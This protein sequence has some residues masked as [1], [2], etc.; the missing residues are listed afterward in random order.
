MPG[1]FH[2][3]NVFCASSKFCREVKAAYLPTHPFSLEWGGGC[4][5][6]LITHRSVPPIWVYWGRRWKKTTRC[7]SKEKV[8]WNCW[9]RSVVGKVPKSR[10]YFSSQLTGILQNSS[11]NKLFSGMALAMRIYIYGTHCV[12]PDICKRGIKSRAA[13]CQS[14]SQ[15]V[16]VAVS[17][18]STV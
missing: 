6:G 11:R 2:T 16:K 8:F 1:Q 14:A 5:I 9:N 13:S 10:R 7:I 18:R 3:C 12:I 15:S 4:R 17:C